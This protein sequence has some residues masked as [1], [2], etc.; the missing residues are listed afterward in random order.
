M[1]M[2]DALDDSVLNDTVP[3]GGQ[4]AGKH[5]LLDQFDDSDGYY[6]FQV[7]KNMDDLIMIFG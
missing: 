3:Q 7:N 4:A 5:G 1:F 6:N 2:L